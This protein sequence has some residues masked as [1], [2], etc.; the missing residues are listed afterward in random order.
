MNINIAE[1][2]SFEALLVRKSQLLERNLILFRL[3]HWHN[4]HP[5]VFNLI[6]H[7]HSSG[8]CLLGLALG[9]WLSNWLEGDVFDLHWHWD[10]VNDLLEHLG[11][12]RLGWL[13]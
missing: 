5:E 12:E 11:L 2:D 13:S 4:L 6:R 1:D 7:N 8:R 3:A 10:S 9:P